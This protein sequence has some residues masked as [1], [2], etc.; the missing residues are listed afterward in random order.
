MRS[1][2]GLNPHVPHRALSVSPHL[3]EAWGHIALTELRLGGVTVHLEAEGQTVTT[4]GLPDDWRLV[5]PSG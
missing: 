4:R 5:T 2:L 1:F 3:P